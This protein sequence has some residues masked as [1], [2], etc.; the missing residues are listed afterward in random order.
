MNEQ[1]TMLKA[2]GGGCRVH[3]NRHC[4]TSHKQTDSC[5]PTHTHTRPQQHLYTNTFIS[6][7]INTRKH[8][9]PTHTHTAHN[10]QKRG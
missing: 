5:P 1:G 9:R 10:T 2:V 3:Q 4:L 6:P 8:N 7:F